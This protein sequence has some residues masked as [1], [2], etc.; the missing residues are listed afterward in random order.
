M[1]PVTSLADFDLFFFYGQL[2]V[3]LENE[4]DLIEGVVQP[5]RSLFYNRNDGTGVQQQGNHPNTM[6]LHFAIRALIT[7]FVGLRNT[8][9]SDGRN[10]QRER[11]LAVSQNSIRFVKGGQ[12][13][14]LDIIIN[15]IS[16]N[17]FDRLQSTE[18]PAGSTI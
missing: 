11:R 10:G 9:V 4:H 1:T 5:K 7:M 2:D 18:A 16:L 12:G 14:E 6:A 15:Y 8:R 17:S 13:Q 3:E